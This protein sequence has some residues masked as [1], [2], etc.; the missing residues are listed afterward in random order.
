ISA[1]LQLC[2]QTCSSAHL[3][4]TSLSA[5]SNS[6]SPL[7][8]PTSLIDCCFPSCWPWWYFCCG[9]GGGGNG[10]ALSHSSAMSACLKGPKET[11]RPAVLFFSCGS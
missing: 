5:V 8:C 2:V 7:T 4:A 9:G 10:D 1:C 3:T 11:R 6:A